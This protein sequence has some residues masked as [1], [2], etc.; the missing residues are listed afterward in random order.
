MA[1]YIFES[2][3]F[4]CLHIEISSR[5][6]ED[7]EWTEREQKKNDETRIINEGGKKLGLNT[8]Q[9]KMMKQFQFAYY[10]IWKPQKNRP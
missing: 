6:N 5:A 8:A 10:A 2:E 7:L 1:Q 9:K 4:I 3:S